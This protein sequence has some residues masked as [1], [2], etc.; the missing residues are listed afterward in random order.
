MSDLNKNKTNRTTEVSKDISKSNSSIDK[1]SKTLKLPKV[2][3]K[4]LITND[5]KYIPFDDSDEV[6]MGIQER[7]ISVT[8]IGPLPSPEEFKGYGDVLPDA[9]DRILKDMEDNSK[10]R[11]L[12]ETKKYEIEDKSLSIKGDDLNEIR[13][14][15]KRGQ[16]FGSIIALSVIIAGSSLAYFGHWLFGSSIILGLFG[17][18]AYFYFK[19]IVKLPTA[20]QTFE[21]SS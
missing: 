5:D 7:S 4:A 14:I 9:P 10:H 17:S 3:I 20:K 13:S 1:P 2:R 21:E 12:M 18:L 6:K 8:R 19:G 15:E 16:T 11:R